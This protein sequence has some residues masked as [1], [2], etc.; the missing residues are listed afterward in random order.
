[1]AFV[2]EISSVRG[3]RKQMKSD[4]SASLHVGP[5]QLRTDLVTQSFT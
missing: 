1:M 2:Y 5:L 3:G 4:G